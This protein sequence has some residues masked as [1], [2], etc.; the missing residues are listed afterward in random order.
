MGENEI[1]SMMKKIISGTS[2][3]TSEKR[4]SNHSARKTVVSKMKKAN[5]QRLAIAKVAGH[6]NIQISNL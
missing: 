3:V 2:L 5:L 1:N 6:R 4:F